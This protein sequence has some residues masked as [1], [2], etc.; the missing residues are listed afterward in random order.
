MVINREILMCICL[1]SCL[2]HSAC[3]ID[4]KFKKNGAQLFK[5]MASLGASSLV[6]NKS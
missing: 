1:N 5:V 6:V 4:V 2:M 3:A